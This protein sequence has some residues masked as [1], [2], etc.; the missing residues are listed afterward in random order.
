MLNTTI[1]KKNIH[2]L[3]EYKFEILKNSTNIKLGKK[4]VK[5]KYAN[6]KLKTLTLV[7]RETCPT[8]CFHWKTCYGN[9]MPFAHR[10]SHEDQ[11]LL[12]KRIYNELLNST[13]KLLLIRLHVL[14][15]FFNVK[16]VKF[17]S[18]MLNT[19]KNIALW[20]FTANNINSKISLSRDIAKEI[21]KLNYS[22]HSHIRFSNDLTNKF[23]GNSYDIVKPVKGES[24]VCPVQENKTAN[25]GTCGL[26]WNQ[27]TQSIIFKTH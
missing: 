10:I 3:N 11:N 2:N 5:G 1:Y 18:I 12:Q 7:E 16:Y 19:F 13:N 17:W 22:Q 6:Y 8:D 21:I 9:N 24:I 23:S 15:D 25:C 27:K 26:C 4:V 14:G 20:G